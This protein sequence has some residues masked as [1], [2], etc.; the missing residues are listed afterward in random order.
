M[1]LFYTLLLGRL[2]IYF[3]HSCHTLEIFICSVYS[4]TPLALFAALLLTLVLS[5][6]AK[7]ASNQPSSECPLC[8]AAPL[9]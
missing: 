6:P 3:S 2:P 5:V 8:A 7:A 4:H 9:V 1:E